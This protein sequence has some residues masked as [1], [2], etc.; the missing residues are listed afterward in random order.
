MKK[1]TL[2]ALLIAVPAFSLAQGGPPP[3]K[4]PGAARMFDPATVVSVSGSV[5]K[6]TRVD[7][8]MGHAGFMCS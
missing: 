7:R 1:M 8:G 6:E 3:G 5:V 2:L 4:G